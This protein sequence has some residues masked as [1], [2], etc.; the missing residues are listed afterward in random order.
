[1]A[2]AERQAVSTWP[3]AASTA[4]APLITGPAQPA[5]VIADVPVA[6]YLSVGGKVVALVTPAAV[7][8]PNAVVCRE[9]PRM[10][11]GNH[12]GAGRP[13]GNGVDGSS[14]L[15]GDGR[16]QLGRARVIV[17][18]WWDPVPRLPPVDDLPALTRALDAMRS[19]LPSWPDSDEPAA[20]QLVAGRELL[21]KA[22]AG[23]ATPA[24]AADRLVGLGPGLTPAGN[25]LLAGAVAG[26]VVFGRALGRR[27][28]LDLAKQVAAEV[29]ERA[30]RTT[31]L[32]ADLARH[33]ASGAVAAPVAA[34]FHALA[35]AG[36]PS[37]RRPLD[38]AIDR[39][40]AV[41]H[42]SGRDLAEGLLLGVAAALATAGQVSP[43]ARDIGA[44]GDAGPLTH[45][46]GSPASVRVECSVDVLGQPAA[47]FPGAVDGP[48]EHGAAV[49]GVEVLG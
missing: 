1:M 35:G 25:D 15:V 19:M 49:G 34:V 11:D 3:A 13:A 29:E 9:L 6:I 17:G 39:L 5:E 31:V 21:A 30:T 10:T 8:L 46:A 37:G 36:R 44:S 45:R 42:T 20:E 7:P 47:E 2:A 32:A 43:A 18:R 16:I 14:A 38:S 22:L 41:G 40:V 27:S 12:G 33:A 24:A 4:I 28:A 48:G 26:L 23:E